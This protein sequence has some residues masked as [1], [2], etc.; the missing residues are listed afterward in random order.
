MTNQNDS[1]SA[2]VEIVTLPGLVTKAPVVQRGQPADL[3]RSTSHAA[4][5]S[6]TGRVTSVTGPRD[7]LPAPVRRR[8][9]DASTPKQLQPLCARSKPHRYK[10]EHRVVRWPQPT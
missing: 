1:D 10:D 7:L 5:V 8:H 9:R 4:T 6:V 3:G 2:Q